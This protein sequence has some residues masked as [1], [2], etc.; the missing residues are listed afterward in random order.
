MRELEAE[1]EAAKAAMRSYEADELAA[2][3]AHLAEVEAAEAHLHSETERRHQE[4]AALER[5]RASLAAREADLGNQ[6]LLDMQKACVHLGRNIQR[7]GFVSHGAVGVERPTV[8][9]EG[10]GR[11]AGAQ[12]EAAPDGPRRGHRHNLHGGGARAR[13]RGAGERASRPPCPPSVRTVHRRPHSRSTAAFSLV[14]RPP[15]IALLSPLPTSSRARSATAAASRREPRTCAWKLKTDGVETATRFS[16]RLLLRGVSGAGGEARGDGRARGGAGGAAGS[17]AGRGGRAALRSPRA[18]GGVGRGAHPVGQ[19]A[20]GARPGDPRRHAGADPALGGARAREAGP[21][22]GVPQFEAGGGRGAPG[23]HER[24]G[25]APA[26]AAE[27]EGGGGGR[28]GPHRQVRVARVTNMC[29]P[30]AGV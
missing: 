16:R 13:R 7:L 18:S 20:A 6:E 12:E 1:V 30:L 21:P 4:L 28:G 10:G 27:A 24:A 25:A 3:A 11:V 19:P 8:A 29:R 2:A 9:G 5:N 15:L 23:A 22:R 14:R 17:D 26:R